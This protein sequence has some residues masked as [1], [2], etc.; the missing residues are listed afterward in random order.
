MTI[1]A[2]LKKYAQALAL[3]LP[4][5][6]GRLR[7]LRQARPTTRAGR[8]ARAARKLIRAALIKR[9]VVYPIKLKPRPRP[10]E[11]ASSMLQLSLFVNARSLLTTMTGHVWIQA[12]L[13]I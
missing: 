11:I 7:M 4:L 5:P 2:N 6:F 10:Q 13:P 3:Q 1:A 12:D 9:K 8:I